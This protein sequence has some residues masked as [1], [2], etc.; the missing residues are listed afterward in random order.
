MNKRVY[1]IRRTS[2]GLF[3]L[4]GSDAATRS[5][6]W[7][8]GEKGGKVWQGMGSLKRHL[9]LVIEKD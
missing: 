7:R 9:R 6:A 2:D 8:K 5:H 4:G 3:S 1:K